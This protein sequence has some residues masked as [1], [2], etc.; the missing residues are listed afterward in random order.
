MPVIDTDIDFYE[1][2]FSLYSTFSTIYGWA[3]TSNNWFTVPVPLSP[4]KYYWRVRAY[5]YVGNIG[6][7]SPA[8]NFV[9]VLT[10]GTMENQPTTP[11]IITV[12]P[13]QVPVVAPPA[14]EKQAPPDEII[15]VGP[16]PGEPPPVTPPDEPP[17]VTPPPAPTDPVEPPPVELP[18]V[19]PPRDAPPADPNPGDLPPDAKPPAAQ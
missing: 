12:D 7:W 14:P 5:D 17:P 13:T 1:V 15:S 18:P 3:N 9:V 16:L 4:G 19:E 11:P 2:Q 8:W 10:T 6:P